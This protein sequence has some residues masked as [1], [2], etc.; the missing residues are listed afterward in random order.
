MSYDPF[1]GVLLNDPR[2]PVSGAVSLML[3]LRV[4]RRLAK[5]HG[6]SAGPSLEAL[7]AR[8]Q[9]CRELLA[10][11]LLPATLRE[12]QAYGLDLGQPKAAH[13]LASVL[14]HLEAYLKEVEAGG[15]LEPDLALWRAVDL[16][17]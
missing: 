11:G 9:A 1:D 14:A 2:P 15:Y 4:A 17:L 7:K 12:L 3:H 6:R 8:A 13:S 5:A 16:E 10:Q